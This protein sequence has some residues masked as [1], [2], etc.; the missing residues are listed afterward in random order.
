MCGEELPSHF[1][2]SP[3]NCPTLSVVG[4]LSRHKKKK[5]RLEFEHLLKI[6]IGVGGEF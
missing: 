4:L 6:K 1:T 3:K 2:V 5:K